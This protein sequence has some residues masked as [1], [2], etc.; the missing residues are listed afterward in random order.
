MWKWLVVAV[1]AIV[2]LAGLSLA[3]RIHAQETGQSPFHVGACLR[4][5]GQ[6][7][8]VLEVAGAWVRTTG[9]QGSLGPIWINSNNVKV[10]QDI[11]N[12]CQ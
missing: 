4:A 12:V 8:K 7:I 9:N 6:T 11:G 5:D 2:L 10:A 3:R 1:N